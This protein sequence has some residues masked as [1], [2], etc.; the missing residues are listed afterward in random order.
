MD[1][2]A[3]T[4]LAVETDRASCLAGA[5]VHASASKRLNLNKGVIFAPQV[6]ALDSRTGD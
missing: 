2:S 3:S 1:G 5:D 4:Y 6:H